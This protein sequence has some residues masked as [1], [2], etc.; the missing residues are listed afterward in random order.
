MA[1]VLH[2]WVKLDHSSVPVQQLTYTQSIEVGPKDRTAFFTAATSLRSVS[3]GLQSSKVLNFDTAHRT[4]QFNLNRRAI[5]T[6]GSGLA[7]IIP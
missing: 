1:C 4:V 7:F 5:P 6:L 3:V 2:M